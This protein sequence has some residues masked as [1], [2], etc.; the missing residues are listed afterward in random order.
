M[1]GS[2]PASVFVIAIVSNVMAVVVDAP[3]AAVGG[4]IALGVSLGKHPAS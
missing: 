4:K 1:A 3:V 2:Y